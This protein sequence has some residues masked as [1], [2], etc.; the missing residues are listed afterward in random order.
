M[1]WS[2]LAT[3]AV[4][5]AL[6]CSGPEVT[7]AFVASL[8]GTILVAEQDGS[9]NQLTVYDG[10]PVNLMWSSTTEYR[11]VIAQ[12][13]R[14][15]AALGI[16]VGEVDLSTAPC[17]D[18]FQS[19][20]EFNEMSFTEFDERGAQGL[21]ELPAWATAV[22]V[23]STPRVCCPKIT[24][25]LITDLAPAFSEYGVGFDDGSLLYFYQ[26]NEEA[27]TTVF[28]IDVVDGTDI[29]EEIGTLDFMPARHRLT[30]GRVWLQTYLGAERRIGYMTWPAETLEFNP[31]TYPGGLIESFLD[32][33]GDRVRVVTRGLQVLTSTG[34]DW[35]LEVDLQPE[36]GGFGEVEYAS[37]HQG[38][39][40]LVFYRYG[41]TY[42]APDDSAQSWDDGLVE[43]GKFRVR[44]DGSLGS[45]VISD[46]DV[47][48]WSP[49]GFE[50]GRTQ[51]G[52]ANEVLFGGEWL[53]I[54]VRFGPVVTM[55]VASEARICE[56][57]PFETARAT[58]ERDLIRA[59]ERLYAVFGSVRVVELE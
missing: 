24:M 13:Q 39:D 32:A 6:G 8:G 26:A 51:N 14:T 31:R 45:A 19:F 41:V 3:A 37:H 36:F 50:I 35:S 40:H 54:A 42:R 47:Y 5:L 11:A 52:H 18:S 44:P 59:G 25:R 15:P 16:P 22:E 2:S 55:W 12:T 30:E 46:E 28:H 53:T 17:T 7:E 21:S 33:D 38:V 4:A 58:D 23:P 27:P 49:G 48:Y 43:A 10:G 1:R 34:N 20:A 29:I 57:V 56:P 9:F